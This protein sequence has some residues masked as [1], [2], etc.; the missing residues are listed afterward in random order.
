MTIVPDEGPLIGRDDQLGALTGILARREVGL[1]LIMGAPGLG[2]RSIL[3]EIRKNAKNYANRRVVPATGALTVDSDTTIDGFLATIEGTASE[4]SSQLGSEP[5]VVLILSY[6]PSRKFD[7]WFTEEFITGTS[8]CGVL[9]V[10]LAGHAS[11]LRRL[12]PA[13][14]PVIKLDDL[15]E[16][17]VADFLRSLNENLV[18]KLE[19]DEMA[20]YCALIRREPATAPA[21][22]DLLEL[23]NEYAR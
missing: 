7:E 13:A 3:R 1:V 17:P 8:R 14:L 9:T 6:H 4:D 16:A 10:F 21:L 11:D 5:A 12:E 23:E 19:A 22:A 18:N 15:P 20:E 2:K